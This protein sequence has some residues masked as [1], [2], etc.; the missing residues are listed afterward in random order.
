MDKIK[1]YR[2]Q[3]IRWLIAWLVLGVTLFYTGMRTAKLGNV[4]LGVQFTMTGLGA[5]WVMFYV[6]Y[7]NLKT[8]VEILEELRKE[9]NNKPNEDN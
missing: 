1:K 3:S 5:I 9:K 2:R 8:K 4:Q 7:V 6:G